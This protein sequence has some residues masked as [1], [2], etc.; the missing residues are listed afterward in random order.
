[1]EVHGVQCTLYIITKI[2]PLFT[3]DRNIIQIHVQYIYSCFLN[4]KFNK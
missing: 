4:Y 1:M 2:N 3:V